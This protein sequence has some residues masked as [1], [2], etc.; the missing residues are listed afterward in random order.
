[1][2]DGLLVAP[3][4]TPDYVGQDPLVIE[5]S[6]YV[7][8]SWH[9]RTGAYEQ[10]LL[11]PTF[12]VPRTGPSREAQGMDTWHVDLN[13]IVLLLVGLLSAYAAYK[14]KEL[15]T[16]VTVGAIVV[17]LFVLLLQGQDGGSSEQRVP[18]SACTHEVKRCQGAGA[19]DVMTPTSTQRPI[20]L[21]SDWP[22]AG[23]QTADDVQL[24]VRR[25]GAVQVVHALSIFVNGGW[26]SPALGCAAA[27]PS[28]APAPTEHALL[29]VL[30]A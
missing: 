30:P 1:M 19:T 12:A 26:I 15:A 25:I 23:P 6:L 9:F 17:T 10:G 13:V 5:A 29:S 16:P 2:T 27:V 18:P 11:A 4:K 3:C 8:G 14:W 22:I 28:A 20:T 7:Q 24:P 21:T